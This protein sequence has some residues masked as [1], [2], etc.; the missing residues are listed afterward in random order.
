MSP[1]CCL[2]IRETRSCSRKTT[3]SL[4]FWWR[5]VDIV[6]R[7]ELRMDSQLLGWSS[8]QVTYTSNNDV[9][10]S[11]IV[12]GTYAEFLLYLKTFTNKIFAPDFVVY[13]VMRDESFTYK[14]LAFRVPPLP[15]IRV[16]SSLTSGLP[17]HP[18]MTLT[19]HKLTHYWPTILTTSDDY[20]SSNL[21]D[22]STEM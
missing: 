10:Y 17:C 11:G 3:C 21:T 14:G 20:G 19:V 18:P 7:M 22:L 4:R 8:I 15:S 5:C 9:I 12:T 1:K 2:L 16:G 6:V 13:K